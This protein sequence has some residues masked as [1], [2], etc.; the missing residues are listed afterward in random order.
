M[1]GSAALPRFLLLYGALYG[2]YGCVSPFLPNLLAE[3]GLG[4]GE[5]G[6]VLAAATVMR[7][8]AGPLAGRIADRWGATRRVLA[9][10]AAL[11]GL[12]A[13]AHLAGH[14]FPALMVIGLAYAVATAPLAPLADVLALA[15]AGGRPGFR[16][17][18]V[19]A[20]GSAAFIGAT[21]LVGWLVAARGLDAAILCGGAVFLGAALA[22][23]LVP[24]AE[25][26]PEQGNRPGVGALLRLPRFRR[27]L[28]VA[29]L[30]VGAHALHEGFSMI[31]WR[32]SGIGAGPAGLLWS[33][34]V[35][36]EIVVFLLVGPPLL[37]RI[38]LA[39]GLALAAGAGALRWA[40]MAQ[41]TALPWLVGAQT[42]H[43]LTFAL[44]HLACLGLIEASVPPALRAT[45][46]TLYG[47]VALGLAGAAL[48]LAA[49]SLYGAL[50]AGAFWVM[51][52]LSL[53]ALPLALGLRE[54]P[55]DGAV[56]R[57]P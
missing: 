44:L 33:E 13:L 7:L 6:S 47:T 21:S 12:A 34:A 16:Y 48:T 42:L 10:S 39:G 4:S 28:V 35:A 40:V 25:R 31:L 49:G 23:R 54:R 11:T 8:A 36:A 51:A 20:A 46:L 38:G 5:I 2:G 52:A 32:A 30:V 22:A 29:A 15:A 17:G 26:D 55:G 41:T 50:G 19:R 27:V 56:R 43:G 57:G 14:G 3:R 24:D 1:F 18:T 9:L 37:D 45:A 53:A